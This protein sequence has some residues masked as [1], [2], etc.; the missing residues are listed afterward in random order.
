MHL[1][2][3]LVVF[4]YFFIL[5]IIG[6]IVKDNSI[7]DIGWGISFVVAAFASL[8]IGGAFGLRSIILTALVSLWGVRLAWHIGRRN[9]GKP[10]DFRYQEFRRSWGTKFVWLKAFL[11]VYVLQ[12]IIS[13]AVAIPLVQGN[14]NPN[15]DLGVLA[16]IGIALWVLGF[17][18]EVVGDAQLTA[19]KSD[20][21]N[22]GKLINV[23][24]WTLTRHPNY[25]GDSTMWFGIFFIGIT[26]L[27]G[28]WTLIGP[29]VMYCIFRFVTGPIL[30]RKYEGRADYDA[31]KQ[32][33]S[34]L[35]PWFPKKA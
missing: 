34:M 11:H 15:Q 33:T 23:G 27:S 16:Y 10:E 18:F 22:K 25:F 6:Q 28:L 2:V 21:E 29:A 12:F 17:Y 14:L 26:S 35:I 30:E 3:L 19:F 4:I 13:S 1:Q 31:Y 20:P 8:F 7:V 32:Q 24:L 5:F 9:I